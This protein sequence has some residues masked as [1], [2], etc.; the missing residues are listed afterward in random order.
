M[1]TLN[2]IAVFVPARAHSSRLSR[3]MLLDLGG[4]PVL[5]YPLQ[6]MML[7]K[8]PQQ[9]VLCTTDSPEDAEI[10]QLGKANG[11]TAFCG[12][13]EDILQRYLDAARRFGI[14][15]MVNVD[16]DDPFCSVSHVDSIVERYLQT[17]ADYICCEG[18]PL[19][20]A[21]IGVKIEALTDVCARKGEHSTQGWAKY[22]VKSGRYKV[23]A[24][25]ASEAMTRPQY[26]MT[27]DYPEDMEFFRTVVRR[28]A[29]AN[30][31]AVRLEEV[32]AFLDANPEIASINQAVSEEYWDRFRREHGSFSLNQ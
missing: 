15:L 3:K 26:R 1:P 14:E 22:F 10:V 13:Q 18:L 28:L 16:G 8:L 25:I 17:N 4:W 30:P 21:P 7:P 23:E 6:R 27:L 12:D 2:H 19:G 5:S 20:G 24:I 29:P 32:I 11:W 9:H 31:E